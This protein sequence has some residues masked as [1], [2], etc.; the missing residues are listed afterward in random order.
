M[1]ALLREGARGGELQK[2]VPKVHQYHPRGKLLRPDVGGLQ[3]EYMGVQF[4]CTKALGL[5]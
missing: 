5:A 3:P 2:H 1:T 4:S